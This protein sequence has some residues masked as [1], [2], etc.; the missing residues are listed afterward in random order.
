MRKVLILR[1]Q[2]INIHPRVGIQSLKQPKDPH[3]VAEQVQK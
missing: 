3:L 1:V 2:V